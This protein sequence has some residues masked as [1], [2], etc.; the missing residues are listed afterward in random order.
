VKVRDVKVRA[1]NAAG[2][3]RDASADRARAIIPVAI[4]PVA[5]MKPDSLDSPLHP[6]DRTV[7]ARRTAPLVTF[8]GY[9]SFITFAGPL[10]YFA[11]RT[12][13]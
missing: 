3:M 2:I 13:S 7:G 4:V 10:I 11:R 6:S 12:R 1:W 8:P 9:I 5:E